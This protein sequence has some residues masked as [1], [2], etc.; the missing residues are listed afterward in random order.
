VRQSASGATTFPY[1][2]RKASR[3]FHRPCARMPGPS[4]YYQ[5]RDSAPLP[6]RSPCLAPFRRG[7]KPL[8]R[9]AGGRGVSE[10]RRI[11][12]HYLPS[13]GKKSS[14]L[15]IPSVARPGLTLYYQW[16]DYATLPTR[17]PCRRPLNRGCPFGGA[18]GPDPVEGEAAPTRPPRTRPAHL[19]E[20]ISATDPGQPTTD[21]GLQ[22][23]RQAVWYLK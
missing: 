16:C 4:L 5:C 20:P 18:Q 10:A 17:P 7:W 21:C 22:T 14:E 6:N 8:P 19:L 23:L 13:D 12:S 15:C 1:A 3:A 11:W 2:H 9:G